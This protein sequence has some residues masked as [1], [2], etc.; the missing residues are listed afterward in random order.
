MLGKQLAMTADY[1]RKNKS[2]EV[3]FQEFPMLSMQGFAHHGQ[4]AFIE[5][6]ES[7]QRDTLPIHPGVLLR[8]DKLPSA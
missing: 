7:M 8:D 5:A 6:G 4:I 3:L 2:P 1:V